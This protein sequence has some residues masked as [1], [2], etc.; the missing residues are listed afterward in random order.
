MLGPLCGA[1]MGVCTC[2][3][4]QC[5]EEVACTFQWDARN[6]G[7][8]LGRCMMAHMK[9]LHSLTNWSS[10]RVSPLWM[11]QRPA[12]GYSNCSR[13][14]PPLEGE[15]EERS[16]L[17]VLPP[18]PQSSVEVSGLAHGCRDISGDGCVPVA[19]QEE[20]GKCALVTKSGGDRARWSSGKTMVWSL[21]LLFSWL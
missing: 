11:P 12:C 17:A 3:G 9:L 5:F 18:F 16:W 20:E 7:G 1:G 2:V 8:P 13:L 15:S 14:Q 21:S 19:T 4:R 6:W 10:E